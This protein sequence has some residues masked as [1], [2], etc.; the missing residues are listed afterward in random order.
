MIFKAFK[1]FSMFFKFMQTLLQ[2][3]QLKFLRIQLLV[4]TITKS[5]NALFITFLSNK[6]YKTSHWW[7]EQLIP[8]MLVFIFFYSL[9]GRFLPLSGHGAWKNKGVCYCHILP[10]ASTWLQMILCHKILIHVHQLFPENPLNTS[11]AIRVSEVLT[12]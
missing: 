6:G 10:V 7:A 3:M 12:M 11:L 8:S 9:K 4:N 5:R 2:S 1:I